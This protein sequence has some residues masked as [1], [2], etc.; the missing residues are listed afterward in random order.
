MSSE[1]GNAGPAASAICTLCPAGCPVAIVP[2]GPD[3]WRSEPPLTDG[4]GLCPRGGALGQLLSHRRRILAPARRVE[5]RLAQV[6]G[7]QALRAAAEAIG[8][9][10]VIVCLDAN[11]PCEQ[12]V[13]AAAWCEAWAGASL[14]VVAEPA[15]RRMLLGIEAAGGEYLADGQLSEC[16]GFVI[17]GDAFASNPT[18]ARGVFDRRQS[19]ARTPVVA[20]DP[21]AGT[22]WK[23][24]THRV[25]AA[26]GAELSA[27]AAVAAAAGVKDVDGP[28]QPPGGA[29]EAGTAIAACERLAVLVAAEYAR[30]AAWEQVGLLAGRLAGALGGGVAPQTV[31]ANALGAVRLAERLG[32]VG[33]EEAIAGDKPL[34]VVGC[35]LLG[36]LGLTDRKI[37]VAAAGLPNVTTDA[38]EIVLPVAMPG[39]MSGT[40]L[41]GAA[42]VAVAS[43][44]DAPAGVPAPGELIGALAAAAGAAKGDLPAGPGPLERLQPATPAAPAGPGEMPAAV[45]VLAAQ[46][47]DVGCGT[48]TGHGSWQAAAGDV[49]ELRLADADALEMNLRNLQVVTVRA[50]GRSC[51]AR[52]RIAPGLSPGVMV[53]P[54]GCTAAR[55]LVPCCADGGAPAAAPVAAE[56]SI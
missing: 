46:A 8:G 22:A 48:L 5:G 29:V 13:A 25:D 55:A 6:S 49:P 7:A 50:D 27:L 28:A 53:L 26:P 52:V 20:I 1:P 30:Y 42:P 34:V 35:D 31:G 2:S 9:G 19:H 11:V 54:A 40:Y 37:L 36:M 41:A 4:P 10:E 44:M 32:C 14:C 23:F 51:R 43:V 45:L 33:L 3:A 17:V 47:A 16:D 21:A 12:I 56:V 24:A 39:E 18:C 38:A 15:D